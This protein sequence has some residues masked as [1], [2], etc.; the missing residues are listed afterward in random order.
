MYFP[1]IGLEE[2]HFSILYLDVFFSQVE[3][4]FFA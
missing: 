3:I 4:Y 2:V 1:E